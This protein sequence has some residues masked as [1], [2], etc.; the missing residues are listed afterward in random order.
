[1]PTSFHLLLAK[2]RRPVVAMVAVVLLVGI[3]LSF[4]I[5][6]YGRRSER[7]RIE[8]E[9]GRR[10][11]MRQALARQILD[12]YAA[13]VYVLKGVFEGSGDVSRDEFR[14]V[15]T[16]I[17]NRYPVI[18]ALEWLPIVPAARRAEVEA[19]VSRELGRPF[20]FTERRSDGAMV[21]AGSR[22]EY[23]PILYVEPLAG[24]ERAFGYDAQTAPSA[25]FL[26]RARR[27]ATF[28][29][30]P[31]FPLVQGNRGVVMAW[32]VL[33]L[34][35]EKA[36]YCQGLA[37]AV[38]RIDELLAQTHL[39]SPT[40]SL[41]MLYVDDG[42]TGP[43]RLLYAWR[44][45]AP[46]AEAAQLTEAE[47]RAGLH[48]SYPL[49]LGGRRWLAL[50]RPTASW[51]AE[52]HTWQ[53]EL[54][55]G[56]GLVFTGLLASLVATLGLR[57]AA[58]TRE[59]EERT[60]E[61]SESRRQLSNLLHSLPGI[62][63]RCAYAGRLQAFFLSEGTLPLL[64]YRPDQLISGEVDIE[65]LVHPEDVAN[66]R[67][68]I[69][70]A[71]EHRTDL[72]FECRLRT[73]SGAVKW[74]L[75]RGRGVH[76][77]QGQ[78]LFV[79]GLAIDVTARRR[80]EADK[81][82]IERKLLESQKLE[83]LGLLAGGIAHDFNNLLTG[84]MGHTSLA[85][86]VP[87]VPPEAEN[88]L[89]KVE[90]GATRAAELC[91]QMLA[92][93][94][95][96][97]F[98]VEA[99]DLNQLVRDTLPLLQGSLVRA[100]VQLALAPEP[101]VVVGDATQ[102]RQVAINLI[103]NAADALP[104]GGG[105]IRVTTG[106]R[107]IDAPFLA[108]A[109]LGDACLPGTYV[110]LEIT[111]NG[112]GMDA[113]TLGKIFDPF[114][115]T[116]FTGRGL[117]L[118]AVLGIVRSHAGALDVQSQPGEGSTFTLLLPPSNQSTSSNPDEAEPEPWRRNGRVLVIDDEPPVREVAMQMLQSFG[119]APEPAGSGTEGITK[120]GHEPAG[121]E[122]IFLDLTMPGM[123]GIETLNRLRAISPTV[124]VLLVS[125]YS[126]SDQ[127][128]KLATT[129]SLVFLQKPFTRIKLE[130]KLRE[131]LL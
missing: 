115:T 62:A 50:Y 20:H 9:F 123:D 117:G 91:Q 44:G 1:M 35:D 86:C 111:D 4:G 89:R 30:T 34:A 53:A 22:P 37:Q 66:V 65:N 58:I 73:R 12:Y 112:C 94:G 14:H 24:N 10:A 102:L 80:A 130:Q 103:L 105:T 48:R 21:R 72:E 101:A 56:C 63:Y 88:H 93:S 97:R 78:L 25:P 127:V 116:K 68:V 67:G 99:V 17:L 79:E 46:A 51:I 8:A 61:L 52:Q 3:G 95:R 74:V 41:D 129:G 114:F 121:Y 84:I 39:R 100:E 32:P 54:W 55:L 124:R 28:V 43:D 59:V 70:T 113:P 126:E 33:N 29:V 107:E 26:N 90:A 71:L 5:F 69:A 110:A 6:N 122:L 47:M 36:P 87:A 27:T 2:S 98:V 60:A 42:A 7:E 120:F 15:A 64:G 23:L 13:S 45:D 109:R 11:E 85:R 76:D 82:A 19:A 75:V 16:D 38:F 108:R 31:S 128:A 57:T 104:P 81:L 83:S 106:R 92:Y 96:G 40:T 77:G 49:E 125:G 18:A 118:A 131:I 119:L